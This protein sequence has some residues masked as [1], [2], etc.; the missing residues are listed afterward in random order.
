MQSHVIY[1][2]P[3]L[4]HDFW[5]ENVIYEFWWES[6]QWICLVLDPI[7]SK[8]ILIALW[9]LFLVCDLF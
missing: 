4:F 5:W 7:V 8:A 3:L 6:S 1:A 9:E 2:L